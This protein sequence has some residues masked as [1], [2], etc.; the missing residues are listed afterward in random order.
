MVAGLFVGLIETL[1]TNL[2][3]ATYK[4]AVL[5]VIMFLVLIV[6]PQGLFSK[7]GLARS[8]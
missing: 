2:L 8:D 6:R 5:F 7:V 1:T 4:Q 3:S